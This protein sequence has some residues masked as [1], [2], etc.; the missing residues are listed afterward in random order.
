MSWFASPPTHVDAMR[1]FHVNSPATLFTLALLCVLAVSSDAHAVQYQIIFD[2]TW[3]QATHPNA[4]VST[5]HFSGLIGGTHNAN[6]SFWQLGGLAT[7]GIKNMAELGT[8]S[9]LAG[10]VN[11]AIATGDA[12][13]VIQGSSTGLRPTPGQDSTMFQIDT[14]HPLVTLVTMVAPSPDWFV[15][16][17]GL[18]LFENGAWRDN[19]VVELLPYDAGTDSGIAF[20][21]PNLVTSPAEP[22]ALLGAPFT[23][24]PPMGTFTFHLAPGP[25][26]VNADGFVDIF[27]VNLVSQHWGTSGPMGDAN[28]DQMVDI[29][30][31]NLI[32]SN[33]SPAGA[34]AA[35]VP[36]P[37]TV[38]SAAA[39]LLVVAFAASLRRGSRR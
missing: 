9:T 39:A 27:D 24:A 25:G 32:T 37:A 12:Y 10:D 2:S 5:A 6:V 34:G 4:W 7:L 23:G 31:V 8:Q 28:G 15:G 14:A 1:T 16:V 21:S 33:W 3:S 17:S 19:V 18:A 36:E 29:F 30:D 22:I 13:T 26:D 35:A 20:T 11:A 38:I